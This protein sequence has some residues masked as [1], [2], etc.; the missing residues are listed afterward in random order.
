MARS[1]SHVVES[2]DILR[3]LRKA[4]PALRKAILK[5]ADKSIVYSIAEIA[6]NLLIGN[7]PLTQKQK[8]QIR[9]HQNILRRLAERSEGWKKKKQL[10][11]QSGGAFLP[12]LLT[13]IAS[14]IGSHLFG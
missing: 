14:A 4:R 7:I 2:R 12:L 11:N 10:L 5:E 3:V 6:D 9:K 13:V 8:S 1:K